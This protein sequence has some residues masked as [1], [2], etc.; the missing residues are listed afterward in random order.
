MLINDLLWCVI[1]L[2]GGVI[3]SFFF[4]KIGLHKKN[5][6]YN[7]LSETIVSKEIM[8]LDNIY[9]S[10]DFDNNDDI[11]KSTVIF[12]NIGNTVIDKND[13]GQNAPLSFATEGKIFLIMNSS[14][15]IISNKNTDTILNENNIPVNFDYLEPKEE[16][17][18]DIYHSGTLEILGHLKG[19]KISKKESPVPSHYSKYILISM[20]V[21]NFLS[22][23]LISH[24]IKKFIEFKNQ[25]DDINVNQTT[26][27]QKLFE[28]S[29]ENNTEQ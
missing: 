20:I 12:K 22:I 29:Q 25:Q 11:Y 23:V 2:L 17:S 5:I 14:K 7:I 3:T 26:L 24:S 6:E 10:Y 1:G 18:Y 8:L 15:D 19:G 21:I 16:I 9:I 28:Y 27:I 13:F 4:Y